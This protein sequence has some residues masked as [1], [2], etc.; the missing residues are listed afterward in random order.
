M[1]AFGSVFK[2]QIRS[3][4][5]SIMIKEYSSVRRKQKQLPQRHASPRSMG[6]AKSLCSASLERWNCSTDRQGSARTML[7]RPRTILLRRRLS[8]DCRNSASLTFYTVLVVPTRG[9][10]NKGALGARGQC[11]C[12][13]SQAS[14]LHQAWPDRAH[15]DRV[16]S[17][18]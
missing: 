15:R 5:K 10:G 14:W 12:H 9:I 16:G 13:L 8:L 4:R 2:A 7:L 3:Y 11:G 17:F 6:A 1:Q 18:N